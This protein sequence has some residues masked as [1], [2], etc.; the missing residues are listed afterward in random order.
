M[1]AKGG[2]EG[3]ETGRGGAKP[4]AEAAGI[5][6]VLLQVPGQWL[7]LSP[8]GRQFEL[9]VAHPPKLSRE[10]LDF[11]PH[12]GARLGQ[13]RQV[14]ARAQARHAAD[15]PG[16]GSDGPSRG[17]AAERRTL[18]DGGG[19]ARKPFRL[20]AIPRSCPF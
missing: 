11:S 20:A 16:A 3:S 14:R 6:V 15:L 13:G 10:G 5:A 7:C 17:Q 19:F 1:K 4:M 12:R 18:C 9:L 8:L 2:E